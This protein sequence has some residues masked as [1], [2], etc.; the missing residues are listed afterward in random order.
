MSTTTG[1]VVDDLKGTAGEKLLK[2]DPEARVVVNFHGVSHQRRFTP[3]RTSCHAQVGLKFLFVPI[4]RETCGFLR[5]PSSSQS[6]AQP[7]CGPLGTR[8][9]AINLPLDLRYPSHSSPYL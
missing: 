6:N 9:A 1:E 3:A 2:L 4:T 5:Y 7:E 8:L